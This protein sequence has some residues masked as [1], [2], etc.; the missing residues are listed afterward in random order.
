MRSP[1]VSEITDLVKFLD[2]Q[3]RPEMPWSIRD[4]Y[5][6]VFADSNR[7]N[8]RVITSDGNILAH[9]AIKYHLIKSVVGVFK[10]AA[11]GSVVTSPEHRNQGLSQSILQNCLDSAYAD[12]ADFA[13]LWTDLYD[14]YRKL[15]FELAGH[16]ISLILE[17]HL[18]VELSP[19]HK[20]MNTTKVSPENISRLYAQHTLGSIRSSEDIRRYLQIPNTKIYTLWDKD[21]ALKAYAVEGK[22]ADLDSYIHEW[23]GGVKELIELFAHVRKDQNR[24]VV[25]ICPA[26]S[27]NLIQNLRKHDVIYNEGFLGMI[28]IL[29]HENLFSKVLRYARSLGIND[30]V[31]DKVGD[32]FHIGRG[33]KVI[34]TKDVKDL[35]RLLFGP[36]DFTENV[37]I[38][39]P[40]LPIPMW[41]WGWDSV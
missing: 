37:S 11:I 18:P 35:T 41:I 30:F 8:L 32:E 33:N 13:I 40:V 28:K 17:K 4:E 22:G 12:G 5:P 20:V 38:L 16:E 34:K 9:A 10:V 24:T 26:S 2:E 21:Q 23:G 14:F 31:L 15:N 25:V 7:Q 3:L 1:H 19:G 29:H 6:A 36:Y 27:K 39:N